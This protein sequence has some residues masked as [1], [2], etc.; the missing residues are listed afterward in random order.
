MDIILAYNVQG[1]INPKKQIDV[2]K[3]IQHLCW[4]CEALG[5]KGKASNLWSLYQ[6]V[7][8]GWCFS[9]NSVYHDGGRVVLA[10]KLRMFTVNIIQG[11]SQAIYCKVSPK[12]GLLSFFCTFVYGFN[13]GVRRMDLWKFL[14]KVNTSEPWLIYGD[15]NCVMHIEERIGALVRR[16]EIECITQCMNECNMIDVKATGHLFTWNNK[17]QGEAR[18]FSKIDRDMAN[19][20]WQDSYCNAEV[21]FL[22]EGTFDHTLS[23]LIVYPRANSGKKPFR[24]FTMWRHSN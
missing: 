7:F 20:A 23:L 1:L 3:F 4:S 6:R 11:T 24:Y 22:N 9:S 13:D 15:M 12:S 10:W 17:Q 5:N 18:V 21:G 8:D 14:K 19:Q 16:S 2:K